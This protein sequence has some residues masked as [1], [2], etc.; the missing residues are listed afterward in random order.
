MV[1][2]FGVFDFPLYIESFPSFHDTFQMQSGVVMFFLFFYFLRIKI[3]TLYIGACNNYVIL[4]NKTI[5]SSRSII[6]A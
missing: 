5:F 4:K 3:P 1:Q 6:N 2:T